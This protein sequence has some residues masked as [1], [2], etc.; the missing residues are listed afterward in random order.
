MASGRGCG[1][2]DEE[3]AS[4][5]ERSADRAQTRGGAA[6]ATA[7]L[8]RAVALTEDPARRADRALAAAQASLQAGAFDAA[9]GLLVTAE[10]GPLNEIQRARVDMLRGQVAFASGTPT[11]TSRSLLDAAGRLERLDL[12]LARETYLAAWGAASMAGQG[13]VGSEVWRAVQALPRPAGPKRALELLLDGMAQLTA[14]G[15]AAAA[16]ALQTA[17][18]ALAEIPAE[19]ALRW[20]WAATAPSA[21]V[22]DD[23]GV[24]AIAARQVKLAREAG[25]LAQLPLHLASLALSTSWTGDLAGVAALIAEADSV[26]SVTGTAFAPFT[27][28][29]LRA[30]QGREAEASALISETIEQAGARGH[31]IAAANAHWAAAVLYNGLARYEEAASAARQAT[32]NTFEPW[33]STFALPELVEAAVRGGDFE[34]ARDGL[35]RL[36]ART[37]PCGNDW[38]L[39]IDARC[40]A[41]L[42]DG[43]AADDLYREAIERLRRSR[44]Q[45]ELARAHLVY[46]EWLR[47]ESRR[48]D[49]REQLRAAQEMFA[50]IGMEA[51][52]ARAHSELEASGEKVR[53][54]TVETRDD[55]T[56]QEWQI[57]RLARDGLSN[58][59]IGTRLYLSPR[60]VEWHLRNVFN[61]LDIRSRRELAD[62]LPT[63]DTEASSAS[64]T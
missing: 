36:T 9:L 42:S 50:T 3:V 29:R 17:A 26:A 19:D 52:A 4:E 7:F 8:Q 45:P 27:L 63:S 1:G 35:A 12:D 51:F 44:L 60:T 28:T 53:K 46:G 13:E 61:K 39:G 56:A 59:E 2:P 38:A 16:S 6:A 5:L 14:N 32:S 20:G 49:A 62:A 15:H 18:E 11:D 25:V 54:R 31:G 21:A 10:T 58:P 37:Q 43:A 22:W 24:R 23:E 40:R 41:L 34:L 30:L 33:I 57:A 55:L 64:R 47:R 48:V